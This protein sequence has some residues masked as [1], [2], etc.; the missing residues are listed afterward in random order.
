MHP[1]FLLGVFFGGA[2]GNLGGFCWWDFGGG[3][4]GA[5]GGF[6]RGVRGVLGF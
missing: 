3:D 6:G 1:F 2:G 4:L 5:I